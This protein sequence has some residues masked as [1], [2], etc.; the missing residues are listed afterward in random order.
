VRNRTGAFF[1]LKYFVENQYKNNKTNHINKY[2]NMMTNLKIIQTLK[3]LMK[4][5]IAV[6][7]TINSVMIFIVFLY[8][9]VGC[10]GDQNSIKPK[11]NKNYSESE[12]KRDRS[13][14]TPRTYIPNHTF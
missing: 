3:D 9:I 8:I 6:I 14:T 5:I 1:Y 12:P 13:P 10:A 4:K 7:P 11:T 2:I